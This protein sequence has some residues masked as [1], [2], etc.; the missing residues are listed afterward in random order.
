[1]I[2]VTRNADFRIE[3]VYDPPDEADGTRGLVDATRSR[4]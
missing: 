2:M 3:R 4:I 1:M